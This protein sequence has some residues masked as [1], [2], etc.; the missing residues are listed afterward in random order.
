MGAACTK[1]SAHA[2]EGGSG[3]ASSERLGAASRPTKP[4]VGDEN[5]KARHFRERRLSVAQ[6]SAEDLAAA[7]GKVRRD[8]V[9]GSSNGSDPSGIDSPVPSCGC[10]TLAGLR[11]TR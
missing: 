1:S 5:S 2:V 9:Y 8:S 4:A 6:M 3:V 11:N 10:K 7:N